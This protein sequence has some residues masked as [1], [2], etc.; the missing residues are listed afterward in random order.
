MKNKQDEQLMDSLKSFITSI[1]IRQK[2]TEK[3]RDKT[4]DVLRSTPKCYGDTQRKQKLTKFI[5]NLMKSNESSSENKNKLAS[6]FGC[7]K[8]SNIDSVYFNKLA[9]QEIVAFMPIMLEEQQRNY[10][11]RRKHSKNVKQPPMGRP[12]IIKTAKCNLLK[13]LKAR[14]KLWIVTRCCSIIGIS[15]KNFLVLIIEAESAQTYSQR[16]EN[17]SKNN[18]MPSKRK[19]YNRRILQNTPLKSK[20]FMNSQLSTPLV[21][22]N[23]K[24]LKNHWG[25]NKTAKRT[26]A[27]PGNETYIIRRVELFDRN[28]KCKSEI[29]KQ[30][31]T[32]IQ[33]QLSS[34]RQKL[35]QQIDFSDEPLRQKLLSLTK[36]GLE[37]TPFG[38]SPD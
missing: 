10:F 22:T 21:S 11:Q 15:N 26:Y 28:D 27:S 35:T 14:S 5:N 6:K 25:I 29:R 33:V 1:G 36:D 30:P 18:A 23:Q 17:N 24:A 3:T 2:S 31:N 16:L 19:V 37:E 7:R 9:G 38:Y 32:I 12:K 8:R 20:V 34:N 4:I 13:Q